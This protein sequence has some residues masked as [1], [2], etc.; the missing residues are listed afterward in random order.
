V[1]RIRGLS[2][3]DDH[4]P[5][6]LPYCFML[7][8]GCVIIATKVTLYTSLIVEFIAVRRRPFCKAPKIAYPDPPLRCKSSNSVGSIFIFNVKVAHSRNAG[9]MQQQ[10]PDVSERWIQMLRQ[11]NKPTTGTWACVFCPDRKIFSQ[12]ER[13][14]LW[15]HALL[16]HHDRL[17]ADE[18]E[19]ALETFRRNFEAQSANKR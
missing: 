1:Q 13:D 11:N 16:V 4:D 10:Q 19:E 6:A 12:S 18:G 15:T 5:V 9:T 14:S 2:S 8:S 7:T 3:L 17:P